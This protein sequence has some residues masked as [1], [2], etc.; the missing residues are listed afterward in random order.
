MLFYIL[1]AIIGLAALLILKPY[2]I[3]LLNRPE[4]PVPDSI[5]ALRN[6]T[7]I[8][9]LENMLDRAWNLWPYLMRQP[10]T[11]AAFIGL[12]ASIGMNGKFAQIIGVEIL[13]GLFVWAIFSAFD[14]AVP[15]VTIQTDKNAHGKENEP[16]PWYFWLVIG[17]SVATSLLAG[18]TSLGSIGTRSNTKAHVHTAQVERLQTDI[19]RLTGV[20]ENSKAKETSQSYAQRAAA[21]DERAAIETKN[22][23]CGPVCR[24]YLMKSQIARS[25]EAIA[26]AREEAEEERAAKQD[27]LSKLTD[28][29]VLVNGI[30]IM[31]AKVGY[32]D[33]DFILLVS[34]WSIITGLIVVMPFLWIFAVDGAQVSRTEA[35]GRA[36]RRVYWLAQDVKNG[37]AW[38]A[39]RFSQDELLV[40]KSEFPAEDID[41]AIAAMGKETQ[42]AL[43]SMKTSIE[44]AQTGPTHTQFLSG[45]PE[46]QKI[47]ERILQALD[48]L[49]DG[50][51]TGEQVYSA[52]Q[53]AGGRVPRATFNAYLPAALNQRLNISMDESF[54]VTKAA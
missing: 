11:W 26:K 20:I 51:Y 42:E 31:A 23:G 48:A 40:M 35:Y 27:K 25:N 44:A 29:A 38:L 24:D 30:G 21:M 53:M 17:V 47:V 37:A 2:F 32:E 13:I 16:R 9:E 10:A 33:G 39:Q 34:L 18:L 8:D 49:S 1:S 15:F 4:K 41:R 54:N 5:K 36:K 50:T 28:Q 6:A 14:V 19:K 46:N 45:V 3:S 52:Y 12:V 22:G 43:A 7:E